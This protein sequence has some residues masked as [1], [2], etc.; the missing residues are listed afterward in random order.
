MVASFGGL[1]V[2]AALAE[3]KTRAEALSKAVNHKPFARNY[4]V[5]RDGTR[6]TSTKTKGDGKHHVHVVMEHR[7]MRRSAM[8]QITDKTKSGIDRSDR[9]P[10]LTDAQKAEELR[11]GGTT[12]HLGKSGMQ[13][14]HSD[15]VEIFT[16]N[17]TIRDSDLA[18]EE[19]AL[20]A[21]MNA[22][23]KQD[24]KR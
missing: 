12:M 10:S 21:K 11:K 17:R 2:Q 14:G 16:P 15:R 1:A 19:A 22:R 8:L 20:V 6:V 18:K 13:R 4:Y 9:E 3:S 7:G 5:L 23:L 24:R